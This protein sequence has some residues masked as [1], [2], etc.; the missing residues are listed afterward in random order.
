M[1]ERR[2]RLTDELLR[3]PIK[4]EWFEPATKQVLADAAAL[5]DVAGPRELDDAVAVMLGARIH[6]ALQDDMSMRVVDWLAGLADV[7]SRRVSS[8]RRDGSWRGPLYLLYGL[9]AQVP[10]SIASRTLAMARRAH[11]LVPDADALPDW[12][13]VGPEFAGPEAAWLLRDAYGARFALAA[14]YGYPTGGGRHAFLFDIDCCGSSRLADAGTFDDVPAAVAYWRERLGPVAGTTDP[15]PVTGADGLIPLADA[16]DGMP[17]IVGFYGDES[18]AVAD[19]WA[20]AGRRRSLLFAYFA[21]RD[22]MPSRTCHRVESDAE[23]KGLAEEFAAWCADAGEPVA[24]VDDLIGLAAEWRDLQ[25]IGTEHAASPH[26]AEYL[27]ALISDWIPDDPATT[28]ALRML[29]AWFRWHG[30]LAGVP[31]DLVERA[32][33]VAAGE[34]RRADECPSVAS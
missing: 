29:P 17:G 30:G 32:V 11:R 3:S 21:E 7:T 33:A 23:V 20:R 1:S 12:L 2:D 8:G 31:P 14:E 24:G 4:T 27:R 6:Q 22:L 5:P 26:R 18:R 9:A 13:G 19:N 28:T 16:R 34:P 25:V 10:D 15:V